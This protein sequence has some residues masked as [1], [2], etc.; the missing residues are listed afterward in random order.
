[1]DDLKSGPQEIAPE[2]ALDKLHTILPLTR[3]N[4]PTMA[5][6]WWQQIVDAA[7][8]TGVAVTFY[9]IARW[10]AYDS[11]FIDLTER[12]IL[13]EMFSTVCL[14][15]GDVIFVPDYAT[16]G[17]FRRPPVQMPTTVLADYLDAYPDVVFQGVNDISFLFP[18]ARQI[19]LMMHEGYYTHLDCSTVCEDRIGE[20]NVRH[21]R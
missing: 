8:C 13:S 17:L 12:E 4:I 3:A 11:G 19:T 16:R 14:P 1:M 21:V 6:F 10:E 5:H 9:R 15:E 20:G 18:E 2:I 7:Q